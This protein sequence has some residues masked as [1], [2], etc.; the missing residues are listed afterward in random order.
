MFYQKGNAIRMFVTP[1]GYTQFILV[2]KDCSKI[3]LFFM[4]TRRHPGALLSSLSLFVSI[5]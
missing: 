1:Q 3:Y 4:F 2:E 5:Q